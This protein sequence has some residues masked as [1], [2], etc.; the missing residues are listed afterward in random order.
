MGL[1]YVAFDGDNDKWAYGFMKGWSTNGRVDFEFQD[2]HDLDSM[3]GRAQNEAYVKSKL[4]ERLVRSEAFILIVGE[5]TKYLYKYVR[6][7]IECALELA[8]PIIVANL[9]DKVVIDEDRCPAILRNECAIHIPFRKD[10]IKYAIERYPDGFRSLPA[11]ERA[12][13]PRHY[14]RPDWYRSMGVEI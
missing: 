14:N 4:R 13:G 6:W 10:A 5:K 1:V 8:L 2:A 3:T 12:G 7:E 11:S 9:N